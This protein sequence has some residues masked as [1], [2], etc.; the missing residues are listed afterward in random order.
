MPK[1]K[2]VAERKH[3]GS[4]AELGCIACRKLGHYDT[5]A[6][7]HHIRHHTGM[8]RRASHFETIPLC[9]YHHR[10]GNQSFHLNPEYFNEVFGTQPQLLAETYQW[11]AVDGCRCGCTQKKG[12]DA[13]P[14]P[15][16]YE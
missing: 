10:T 7:I 3:L 4:V 1:S 11:L 5:P 9:P 2:T 6:E 14:P 16:F 8:G 15:L 13:Y 12:A